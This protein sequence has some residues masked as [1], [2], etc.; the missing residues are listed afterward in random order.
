MT[1]EPTKAAIERACELLNAE[2]PKGTEFRW[3][4]LNLKLSDAALAFAHFID[5]V[6]DVAKRIDPLISASP[7]LDKALSDLILP[8]PEPDV[9]AEALRD[10]MV[11]EYADITPETAVPNSIVDA[12]SIRT[13]LKALGYEIRKI[14]Q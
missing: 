9:L 7:S 8:D 1:D 14:D 5:H 13:E 12:D 6:S 2:L 10:V 4:V 3:D 11:Y